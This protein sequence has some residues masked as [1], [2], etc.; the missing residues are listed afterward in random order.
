[1]EWAFKWKDGCRIPQFL[2]QSKDIHAS[3]LAIPVDMSPRYLAGFLSSK[4][5]RGTSHFEGCRLRSAASEVVGNRGSHSVLGMRGRPWWSWKRGPPFLSGIYCHTKLVKAIF[6]KFF[7]TSGH[8]APTRI[9]TQT[10][11]VKAKRNG[12]PLPNW[13]STCFMHLGI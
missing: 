5:V 1:M 10:I 6:S 8:R 2:F 11:K 13:E 12:V 7:Q 3:W 4:W 9:W